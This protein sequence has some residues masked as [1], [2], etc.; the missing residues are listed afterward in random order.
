MRASFAASSFDD[1]AAASVGSGQGHQIAASSALFRC[2]CATEL[3]ARAD[4]HR[5]AQNAAEEDAML[6]PR[7]LLH[8]EQMWV[9][10]R[11]TKLTVHMRALATR[12]MSRAIAQLEWGAVGAA[13]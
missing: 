11:G 10:L 7:F 3:E 4:E 6:R 8:S 5:A 2:I 1:S 12:M 9:L 13:P